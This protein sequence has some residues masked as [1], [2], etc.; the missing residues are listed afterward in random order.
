MKPT[1]SKLPNLY[2]VGFMGVGKSMIGRRLA[3]QLSMHFVDSDH[4][5]EKKAGCS[6]KEIFETKG[7]VHFRALEKDFIDS[8]HAAS[9]QVVAC[10][11]GLVIQPGMADI[12]K[13]R[14][15]VICLFASI[16][17]IIERTGRNRN[18]P[19]LEVEEREI[20]IRRLFEERE[21]TYLSSGTCISTDDRSLN[22]IINH[23]IRV[24]RSQLD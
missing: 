2:L 11:G 12:L 24:Y 23:V 16:E 15:V 7:E 17:T 1:D 3:K 6:I 14:G 8:G 22:D 5:I 18:R 4:A 20:E 19:L 9:G 10:G 21:A 13:S